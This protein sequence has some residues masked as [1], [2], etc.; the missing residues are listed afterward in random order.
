M[1]RSTR[2]HQTCALTRLSE[3]SDSIFAQFRF[4]STHFPPPF[5]TRFESEQM[6][7]AVEHA[8]PSAE[9]AGKGD[10]KPQAIDFSVP[11]PLQ[12]RWCM[13]CVVYF[14]ASLLSAGFFIVAIFLARALVTPSNDSESAPALTFLFARLCRYDAPQ[15]GKNWEDKLQKINTFDTVEDFWR[16]ASLVFC[17]RCA[18]SPRTLTFSFS[19]RAQ[20]RQQSVAALQAAALVEL[21]HVQEWRQ[22][23][24]GGSVQ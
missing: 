14:F 1:R 18:N 3:L 21:S 17:W 4:R 13:W 22:A 9:A 6:A 15:T 7:T 2:P 16:F 8:A 23:R 5:S 19:H 10:A 24:M 20:T 11:H 12:N